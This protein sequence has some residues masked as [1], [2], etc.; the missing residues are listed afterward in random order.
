MQDEVQSHRRG[1]LER[2]EIRL[3]RRNLLTASGGGIVLAGVGRGAAARTGTPT[4]NGPWSFTDDH[5]VTVALPR[6]P[7]RIVAHIGSAAT[8]WDYGIRPVGVFGPIER[9]DG[10]P[11]PLIGNVDLD[12]VASLGETWGEIDL[13]ALVALQPDLIIGTTYSPK[14]TNDLWGLEPE[15]AAQVAQIAPVVAISVFETSVTEALARFEELAA[16]LG[17]DL[18]APEVA[19]ARE[20]FAVASDALREAASAQ[21]GL[22]VLVISA[23]PEAIYVAN[24][25]AASDLTYFRE[26]GV[27]LVAPENP[28]AYWEELS[29][30]QALKYPADLLLLDERDGGFTIDNLAEAPSTLAAHPAV[31]AGQVGNWYTEFVLSYDAFAAILEELATTISES[32]DDVVS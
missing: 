31:Q 18:D 6:R 14:L 17:S 3:T 5:D 16:S 28:D 29:W 8:L 15:V 32:R 22:L 30:E 27:E 1:H 7:E 9:E 23:W 12:Q 24:P 2:P 13:E 21:P 19:A 4:P 10:S 20:R 25:A 26:L 11:D